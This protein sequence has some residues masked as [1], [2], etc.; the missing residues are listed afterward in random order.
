[1][2]TVQSNMEPKHSFRR[3]P[4][5]TGA[6]GSGGAWGR[7]WRRQR[8]N[9]SPIWPGPWPTACR[10][11]ISRAGNPLTSMLRWPFMNSPEI[12]STSTLSKIEA[13]WVLHF[14]R[15]MESRA[16]FLISLETF[17]SIF[18]E[19]RWIWGSGEQI[20]Y[21]NCFGMTREGS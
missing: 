10:E 12:S 21:G 8:P 11:E 16:Y 14:Q 13:T 19:N 4:G 20:L 18:Y 17:C 9:N 3:S 1:M 7:R 2:W 15:C 6:A 5:G